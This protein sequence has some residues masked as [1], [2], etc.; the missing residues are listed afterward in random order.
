MGFTSNFQRSLSSISR[1]NRKKKVSKSLLSNA[2]FN[3]GVSNLHRLDESNTGD[4]FC[5]PHLYFPQLENS[6]LD[7][8]TIK[9]AS[10]SE[11]DIQEWH[12]NLINNAL[13]I[14]GGGLLNREG[15]EF[16]MKLFEAMAEKGKKT[17]L[18]G[19]G[20]NSKNK[21]DFNNVTDYNVDINKFGLTGVRDF[22]MQG[23]WVPCVSCMH[24]IFDKPFEE[25]HDVGLIYHKK[26]IKNK[27]LLNRLDNYPSTSNTVDLD[28]LI[29]FIGK[30]HCIV[31]DS[32]HAMYWALLLNKKVITVP[33]SSKFYDF[34]YPAEV[35]NFEDFE[36][37]LKHAKA[38]SGVLEE[39]REINTRFSEKVF[40]YLNL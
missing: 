22:S 18:W 26:T 39:C 37:K 38:Y 2:L 25:E 12:D 7:I 31:T 9:S 30:S 6:G 19:V 1:H 35:S 4:F 16:Q 40:N 21:K 34:K 29:S 28:E 15:F 36:S 14:G 33:N 11:S 32:Y 13:I 10:A 8:H 24:D 20:H 27:R 17:V 23:D 3:H 5:A